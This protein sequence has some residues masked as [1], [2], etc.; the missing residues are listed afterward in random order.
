MATRRRGRARSPWLADIAESS[1]ATQRPRRS[2]RRVCAGRHCSH[3][4]PVRGR[5]RN[6]A[7][8]STR[9]VLL[10]RRSAP[11]R[12]APRPSATRRVR[13]RTRRAAE[14]DRDG[15]RARANAIGTRSGS[16]P[17]I[18][19]STVSCDEISPCSRCH[20]S[21]P[22]GA[23]A[24]ASDSSRSVI[25]SSAFSAALPNAKACSAAAGL[26][27]MSAST[28]SAASH[29]PSRFDNGASGAARVW[30]SA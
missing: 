8:D 20:A 2:S 3:A 30:S 22:D 4:A 7:V 24:A 11:P 10:W 23:R 14:P 21:D 26:R 16:R 1:A 28:S 18:R 27:A 17:G 5:R 9:P 19:S 12:A 13:R 25:C 15:S 29:A 6:R